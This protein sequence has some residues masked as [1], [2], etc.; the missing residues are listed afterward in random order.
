MKIKH[1]MI[2]LLAPVMLASCSESNEPENLSDAVAGKYDG[3]TVA[4]CAYFDGQVTADQSVTITAAATAN[5]VD[6]NFTSTTWGT[7]TITGATVAAQGD[8]Y[9]LSGNGTSVMGMN[10]NSSEY[11]CGF[12]GV[13]TAGEA[14]LSFTCPAIMGGL[15]ISFKTGTAP[16]AEE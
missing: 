10:G 8:S 4:K 5:K 7:M 3:Y 1:L 16:V 13:I 2:L 14:S 15:T 6:V 12:T 9:L 11:D